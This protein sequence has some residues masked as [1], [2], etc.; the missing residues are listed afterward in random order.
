MKHMRQQLR[1]SFTTF[2]RV[3][4]FADAV[5]DLGTHRIC[6]TEVCY[7]R[8]M[9]YN[10]LK[11]RSRS[12]GLIRRIVERRP[13]LL[14]LSFVAEET[15]DLARRIGW[16]AHRRQRQPGPVAEDDRAETPPPLAGARSVGGVAGG[17]DGAMPRPPLCG[18]A[19]RKGM[20]EKEV[21]P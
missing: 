2:R 9:V 12:R 17:T 1:E 20:A 3:I 15:K 18:G 8:Q 16:R 14:E 13:D 19:G 5:N 21:E 10:V 11:G 4:G 6:G 7:S